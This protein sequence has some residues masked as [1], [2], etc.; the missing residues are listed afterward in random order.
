MKKLYRK[1]HAQCINFVVSALIIFCIFQNGFAQEVPSKEV[2]L[3]IDDL[4]FVGQ[5][6]N[7]PE[8][9]RREH[10]RFMEILATLKQD[11]VPATGFVIA[12]AI[13]RDQGEWL[14]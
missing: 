2:A 14:K 13:E 12:G 11:Q 9:Y 6:Q 1:W 7:D 8:K 10:R 5:T 4:P 3:T